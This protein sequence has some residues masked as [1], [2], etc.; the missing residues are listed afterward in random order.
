MLHNRLSQ[1]KQNKELL[2]MA[3]SLYLYLNVGGQI[4]PP[5]HLPSPSPVPVQTRGLRQRPSEGPC[6]L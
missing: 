4:D 2:V 6:S 1:N 3:V 5:R